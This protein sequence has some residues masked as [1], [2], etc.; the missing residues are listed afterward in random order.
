M[1]NSLRELM[2]SELTG[3]RGFSHTNPFVQRNYHQ[4][5][6]SMRSIGERYST[7]GTRVDRAITISLFSTLQQ[8]KMA[9]YA[10][11]AALFFSVFSALSALGNGVSTL[12]V[13][14]YKIKGYVFGCI[15][16]AVLMGGAYFFGSRY[17]SKRKLDV[18]NVVDGDLT[19]KRMLVL[20]SYVLAGLAFIFCVMFGYIQ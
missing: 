17:L 3:L 10:L 14:N 18:K 13:V 6:E 15:V 1:I 9:Q 2:T 11:W 19:V 20:M 5:Y 12:V 7:L 8:R 16:I 4:M